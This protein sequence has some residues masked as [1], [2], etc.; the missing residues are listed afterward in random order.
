MSEEIRRVALDELRVDGGTQPRARMD[1]G[2]VEEY[3]EFLRGNPNKDLPPGSSVLDPEGRHWLYDGFHRREAYGLAGRKDMPVVVVDGSQRQ[4]VF[5]SLAANAAHGLKRTNDDKRRAVETMLLDTEWA[6]WSDRKIAA[7]CAVSNHFVAD[8]RK[9]LTV[10]SPSEERRYTTKHGTTTTM[11]TS[12]IGRK[13][14][15]AASPDADDDGFD[16]EVGGPEVSM[17]PQEQIDAATRALNGEIR[18]AAT[19]VLN[20]EVPEREPGDDSDVEPYLTDAEGER[21]PEQALEAFAKAKELGAICREIDAL[22]GRVEDIA[23][24]PGGRLIRLDSFRQQMKDAKG[25]LWANRPTHVCPY[26]HGE[27]TEKPCV[28]CRGEGWTA[29]HV[30]QQAPGNNEKARR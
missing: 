6:K 5:L 29:K 26:C 15:P 25:N 12:N 30:W 13:P 28:C 18:D 2:T 1:Q 21:V 19:R 3:A 7:H 9:S 16:M 24:G 22:I 10:N 11:K 8:V 27:P 14:P 23:K 4:A 20:G 17:P